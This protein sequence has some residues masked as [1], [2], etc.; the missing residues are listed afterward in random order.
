MLA[1]TVWQPWAVA[2]IE[3]RKDV[4]N[5]SWAP[6]RRA[7][8]TRIAIHAG[9]TLDSAAVAHLVRL[10]L[11]RPGAITGAP[12]G[13]IVGTVELQGGS[14]SAVSPWAEPGMWHW[15][16]TD[17]RRLREPVPCRG[18]QGRWPVPADVERLV[19]EREV[20]LGHE[21]RADLGAG[22]GA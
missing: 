1:L 8:D 3:L 11:M 19:L 12:L 18:A 6:P 4:E 7:I 17:P 16:V 9:K 15:L 22:G 10:G 14:R 20:V 5:R 2:L 21:L 13:A